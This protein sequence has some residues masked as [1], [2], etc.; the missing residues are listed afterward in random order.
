M[1]LIEIIFVIIVIGI[2]ASIGSDIIFKLYE[3]KLIAHAVDIASTK[4]HVTLESI[5]NRLTYRIPDTEISIDPNTNA[6]QPLTSTSANKGLEWIG[7]CYEAM[8]GEYNSSLNYYQPGWSGLIDINNSNTNKSQVITPGSQLYLARDIIKVLS[9]NSIDLDTQNNKAAII[10]RGGLPSGTDPILAYYT[11]P[12]P[13]VFTVYRIDDKT[14]G[15]DDTSSKTIYEHYYLTW[16]AYAI[17]PEENSAGDYNLSLYYDF[18]PW[19]GE[20]Y[21]DGKKSLLA[22]HITKFK[23]RKIDKSI[24]LI[25]CGMKKISDD[26]NVTFCGKKVVF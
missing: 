5:A 2:I 17:I 4:T 12:Y 20:E 6:K 1:T 22:T 15:F 13:G 23:F 26:Y 24:E 14:L 16:S 25:L 7:Y 11:S 3:N 10:F 21:S 19:N 18:R 8:R 9:D